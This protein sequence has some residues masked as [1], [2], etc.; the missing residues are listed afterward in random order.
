M[1]ITL[2]AIAVIGSTITLSAQESSRDARIERK[3]E[4]LRQRIE[5][6]EQE[7][8][9]EAEDGDHGLN[10]EA[11]KSDTIEFVIPE[12]VDSVTYAQLP[13]PVEIEERDITLDFNTSQMDSLLT[14]WRERESMEHFETFFNQYINIDTSTTLVANIGAEA[15]ANQKI[16]SLYKYRLFDMVS[17]IELPYN[18]IVRDYIN[19]YINPSSSLMSNILARS[20]YYFPSIEE[21]LALHDLP[22]ELR[23]MPII[24][25]ALTNVSMS[26]AG[27]MGLW[28]FMPATG[29]MYGLEVNYLI[30]ERCDPDKSTVAACKMLKDL[31]NMYGDWTLAIAAY[32]CGPGNVNKAIARSRVKEGTFWDIYDFLPRE[33]RGYVPA[34]I[35]ASYAY[36]Y[37]QQHNITS[38]TPPLPLATDTITVNRIMHLGQVASTLNIPIELLRQLNPQYRRDIIPATIKSY[39]LR[40]PQSYI[41]SY[42]E[43]EDEINAKDS[44]YLKSYINPTNIE[45]LRQTPRGAV[46]IV[47]SGDTLSGIAVRYRCTVRQLMSWNNLKSANRL[48]LGQRIIIANR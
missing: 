9:Q 40:L 7:L 8:T 32:N 3:I 18:S 13:E 25:S 27:A 19:K 11:T 10:A 2:L 37:H 39:S 28:Q 22:T 30:D 42:I 21:Q 23:A 12:I 43:H 38:N 33:T 17:P 24:E 14:E 36:T 31:Y 1:K 5:R 44:T 46:H 16:D 35:A 34:F 41:T 45:R 4:S 20:R 26:H 15:A 47:R 48:S 6:Y 29:K